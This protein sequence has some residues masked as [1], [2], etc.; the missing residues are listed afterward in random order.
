ME[1]LRG[2]GFGVL[3]Q[4]K[5]VGVSRG[6]R[7]GTG[8]RLGDVGQLRVLGGTGV[9]LVLTMGN[10]MLEECVRSF[11]VEKDGY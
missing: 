7:K 9:E 6:N 10:V 4:V 2:E 5:R 8:S 1:G 11:G 3:E